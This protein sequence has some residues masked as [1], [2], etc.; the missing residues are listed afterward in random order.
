MNL[1]EKFDKLNNRLTKLLEE[2][3]ELKEKLNEK[4]YKNLQ[5]ENKELKERLNE[6]EKQIQQHALD[7]EK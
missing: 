7:L 1:L 6:R 4:D 2:N 5:E 3:K